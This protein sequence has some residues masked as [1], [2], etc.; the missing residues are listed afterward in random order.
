MEKQVTYIKSNNEEITI[1]IN[2]FNR[3]KLRKKLFEKSNK[4][5]EIKSD[6]RYI[7]FQNVDLSKLTKLKKSVTGIKCNYKSICILENCNIKELSE[8]CFLLG[9]SF[10]V[11]GIESPKTLK[12]RPEYCKEIII[13]NRKINTTKRN[14]DIA[15][16]NDCESIDIKDNQTIKEIDL[17]SD[18]V[19]LS[20]N[21]LLD[22]FSVRSDYN[23]KIGDKKEITR[24]AMTDEKYPLIL[25]E[26]NNLELYNCLIINDSN[27]PTYIN[28]KN[29]LINNC[30]I[31]TKGQIIINDVLI[32][33]IKKD[34]DGYRILTDKDLLRLELNKNLKQRLNL[35]NEQIESKS[36]KYSS[37]NQNKKLISNIE[38]QLKVIEYEQKILDELQE[39]FR[40]QECI[41][42]K[43]ITKTLKR[44]PVKY[45]NK[46]K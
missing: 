45:F 31:K 21:F 39:E 25:L 33:Q 22:T 23:L 4:L 16:F 17:N 28:Y 37:Q 18:N 5:I 15:T 30:T 7:H 14:L 24:I 38:T 32:H 27:K 35:I 9:D 41:R 29:I 13:D 6:I 10:Q 1:K 26:T 12:V 42:R 44:K 11:I 8:R 19:S 3:R 2:Y 34:K 43:Q 20:G 46:E 40:N 36:N